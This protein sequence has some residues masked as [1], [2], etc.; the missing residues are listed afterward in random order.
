MPADKWSVQPEQA[1]HGKRFCIM[2]NCRTVIAITPGNAAIDRYMADYIVSALD[3]RKTYGGS[4]DPDAEQTK[5]EVELFELAPNS[6]APPKQRI[7]VNS[8]ELATILAA[9]RFFQRTGSDLTDPEND[10]ATD[11]GELDALGN[12]EINE[13]CER[14]NVAS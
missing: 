1:S 2:L 8:R 7:A 10:I 6:G 4:P 12:D 9:R 14:L 3:L 11:G 13:L 5:A